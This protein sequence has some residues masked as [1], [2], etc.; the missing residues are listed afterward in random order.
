MKATIRPPW[1]LAPTPGCPV[2]PLSVT[3][4]GL[5][6]DGQPLRTLASQHG[7]PLYAYSSAEITRRLGLLR[8]ALRATGLPF[9]IHY[10]MKANRFLPVLGLMRAQGDVGIDACSPRE[11]ERAL[12]VGFAP[13]EVSVTAGMLSDRDL[14]RLCRA[15]VHLNLDTRS[16]LRRLLAQPE[17]PAAVGLRIDPAVKIGY[18]DKTSYGQ[19]KFGF[20]FDRVPE[21]VRWLAQEGLQVDTLHVHCGWGM[22]AQALEPF[23]E[24]LARLADLA[25]GL[26]D[27]HT[28]NVGGGLGARQTEADRPLPLDGWSEAIARHLGPLGRTIA[29]EPG[30]LLVAHAGVLVAEVNTIEER[31]G[32]TWVGVDAGHNLNVYPGYYGIPLEIVDVAAPLD[33]GDRP[34]SVAGNINEAGDIFSHDADLPS[35]REGGLLA[36]Y[37][38][39]AYGASMASDHCMR[40]E[41]AEVLV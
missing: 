20:D 37:P 23:G 11:V 32:T 10:A 1:W 18:G 19:A 13:Q 28:L 31:R 6:L 27:V 25:A 34:C 14:A 22:Q 40:G 2:G 24:V 8:Q 5:A 38:C 3:A 30:T 17:R 33:R 21:V 15:G 9:R 29:C 7:T 36:F 41:V 35:L 26:P 16:V 39:G 4:E 12:Q